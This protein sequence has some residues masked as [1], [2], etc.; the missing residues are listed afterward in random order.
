M[1]RLEIAGFELHDDIAAQFQ[2]V[3]QQIQIKIIAAHVQ[4]DLSADIGKA[5]T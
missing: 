3:E 4:L 5:G 1:L 2:M